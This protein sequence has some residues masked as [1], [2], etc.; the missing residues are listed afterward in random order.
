[1]K[2]HLLACYGTLKSGFYNNYIIETGKLIG[3]FK[4]EPLYTMVSLG[5]YPALRRNGNN[6]I[7]YELWE[8]DDIT[9]KRVYQLEG[10][11]G[12]GESN[13][14]DIDVIDTPHGKAKMFVMDSVKDGRI[15][16]KDG[17]WK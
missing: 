9:L 17:V 16:I 3:T 8:V 7:T 5:S 11:K 1:M 2:K 15:E 13:W 14:Y 10:Y 6:S 4:T 12:K